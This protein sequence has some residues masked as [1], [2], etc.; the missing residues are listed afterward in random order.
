MSLSYPISL[1]LGAKMTLK[2]R[3]TTMM[4][5]LTKGIPAQKRSKQ[6]IFARTTTDY[7]CPVNSR[8][9]GKKSNCCEYHYTT[10][11]ES[12]KYNHCFTTFIVYQ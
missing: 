10:N 6:T 8:H 7:S 3:Y 12:D 5:L 9:I 11:H 2:N 4:D 1:H